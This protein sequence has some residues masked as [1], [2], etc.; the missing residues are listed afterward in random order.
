M[1]DNFYKISIEQGMESVWNLVKIIAFIEIFTDS[2]SK[3]G[4]S[5]LNSACIGQCDN[6]FDGTVVS[7]FRTGTPRM[8][9]GALSVIKRQSVRIGC[10]Y[11]NNRRFVTNVDE[12]R[13][14]THCALRFPHAARTWRG[15]FI[16]LMGVRRT[17]VFNAYS[18]RESSPAPGKISVH[19]SAIRWWLNIFLYRVFSNKCIDIFW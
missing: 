19:R 6:N 3:R 12:A 9:D 5:L 17:R 10:F 1:R 16:A 18:R 2:I 7:L 8:R 11:H 4:T 13:V 14:Q 15:F